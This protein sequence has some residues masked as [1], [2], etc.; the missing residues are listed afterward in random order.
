MDKKIKMKEEGENGIYC[1]LCRVHTL[2]IFLPTS[3]YFL[4]IYSSTSYL[5]TRVSTSYL[6]TY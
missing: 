5:Y 2:H 4:P 6:L 1:T 3:I